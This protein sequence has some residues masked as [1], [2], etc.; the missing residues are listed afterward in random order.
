MG[1]NL[2]WFCVKYFKIH[3]L[4]EK[5]LQISQDW[6]LEAAL[7]LYFHSW[8][9][10]NQIGPFTLRVVFSDHMAHFS[11]FTFALFWG[12]LTDGR[13]RTSAIYWREKLFYQ[14]FHPL[15]NPGID[16]IFWT[17]A[18]YFYFISSLPDFLSP[19]SSWSI[20]ILSFTMP[21]VAQW[22]LIV[23]SRSNQPIDFEPSRTCFYPKW[24]ICRF[25]CSRE[26]MFSVHTKKHLI[27]YIWT[28]RDWPIKCI[29][30]YL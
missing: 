6:P 18:W 28:N 1:W 26:T 15:P 4:R 13:G 25:L 2:T 3:W 9:K 23:I 29:I 30:T 16:W 27:G 10:T 21:N 8:I 5:N 24:L 11:T 17:P 22:S 20:I 19:W 7:D 14:S 12:V